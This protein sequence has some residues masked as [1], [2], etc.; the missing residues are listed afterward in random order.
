MDKKEALEWF[1][2]NRSLTNLIPQE[3]FDTWNIRIAEA[4]AAMMQQAYLYLKA[5][6]EGLLK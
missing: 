1:S 6:K 3:P 4:D 5:D 2:G